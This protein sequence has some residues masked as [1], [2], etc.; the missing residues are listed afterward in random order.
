MKNNKGRHSIIN[1]FGEFKDHDLERKYSSN[2]IKTSSKFIRPISLILGMVYF[3][4]IIPDYFLISDQMLFL[5]ILLNR[6][7]VLISIIIFYYFIKHTDRRKH[8]NVLLTIYEI[9]VSLSFLIIFFQYENPD[10]LIQVLGVI[11]III[12]IFIAPNRWIYKIFASVIIYV[13]FFSL[14]MLFFKNLK[15]P[16]L[17]AAIV[18]V[19]IVIIFSS[20]N[21]YSIS[22]YKRIQYKDNKELELLS[23][24]DPLTGIY[25]RGKFNRGIDLCIRIYKERAVPFSLL[26]FD[27]DDFKEIND[28]YG[29]M[30]GDKIIKDVV[31]I[32]KKEIRESDVFFRWGGDEFMIL[33]MNTDIKYAVSIAERI[34]EIID[35]FE[36]QTVGHVSCSFGV[37]S[38]QDGDNADSLLIRGDNVL[39]RAKDKGKNRVERI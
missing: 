13:T 38:Y 33:L 29:H 5:K 25:N 32:I 39:Y 6:S 8:I 3:L 37:V 28:K 18:Y 12:A 19:L 35:K 30:A 24:T 20:I 16:H 23:I 31:N 22:Y 11:V 27:I 9:L 14:S 21:S 36:F 26:L 4:F 15:L 10:F 7:L 17:L 1:W 34:R 2:E